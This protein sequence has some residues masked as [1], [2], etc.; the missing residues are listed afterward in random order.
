MK[1]AIQEEITREQ[2]QEQKLDLEPV[3]NNVPLSESAGNTGVMYF[4]Q[5]LDHSLSLL[6]ISVKNKG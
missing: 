3:L 5:F 4:K 2:V 6:V 1:G